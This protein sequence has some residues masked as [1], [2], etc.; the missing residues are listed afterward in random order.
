MCL[1]LISP[2]DRL[3]GVYCVS[4]AMNAIIRIRKWNS[5][6]VRTTF[7]PHMLMKVLMCWMSSLSKQKFLN[8]NVFARAALNTALR[9]PKILLR[10]IAW[11]NPGDNKL[12]WHVWPI[13]QWQTSWNI[14]YGCAQNERWV[15]SGSRSYLFPSFQVATTAEGIT[16]TEKK[17]RS[18]VINGEEVKCT[19]PISRRRTL[20]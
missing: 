14:D 18:T 16:T 6:S 1:G 5:I 12:Y 11:C 3:K 7:C 13:M 8:R 15:R 20:F 4:G 10:I 19:W 9:T 2:K 17:S